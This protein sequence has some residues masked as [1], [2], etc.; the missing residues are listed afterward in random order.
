M[1]IEVPAGRFE[2][3]LLEKKPLAL[4]KLAGIGPKSA[5]KLREKGIL[6]QLDL[7]LFM[8]RKY[9]RVGHFLAGP[10]MAFERMGTVEFYARVMQVRP[11]TPGSKQPLSLTVDCDGQIFK[12]IWFGGMTKSSALRG[13][14]AN[15]WL[16]I[17]G[18]VSYD[19]SFPE[20]SHPTIEVLSQSNPLIPEQY[21][22][23]EP[24]YTSLDGV[25]DAM[26][27]RA[28]L[29]ALKELLP[30][31]GDIIPRP[32][33]EKHDLPGIAQA[34]SVIH[35][36]EP[37]HDLELFF[38]SLRRAKKRLI[39]EEFYTLQLKMARDYASQRKKA[40]A[41][42]LAEREL[43]RTLIKNLPFKLTGDQGRA[44]GTIAKELDS[45]FPMRRL[46][47]GD[48]GSGKTVVSLVSAAMAIDS[49]HQAAL[50]APTD[51][52][53]RQHV[54]RAQE[55]FEGLDVPICFLGGSLNTADKREALRQ[56]E[57]GEARLII[58]THALF[59]DDIVFERLGL[60]MIDEQ[61][62]FGVEQRDLLL[63]KGE[64][65]HLMSMT[66]TPIPRS[67]AHAI[68]GDLDL[69]VIKEKPPG[70]QPIRTVLRDLTRAPKAYEYIRQR[71][72]EHK[73]QAYFVYPMIEANEVVVNRKN[74]TEAAEFL[75]ETYFKELKLA[76]LHGR[77][78]GQEKADTMSDFAAGKIDILCATTVIEVGVDVA[79]A[80][81]MVIESPEVFGLSQL[82]QLR[83]RV[84]RGDAA[85]MCI[86]LADRNAHDEALERLVSFSNTDDGFE[87]AEVDLKMRGPGLFLGKRQAGMAEF[88]FGDLERDK[89][90][91]LQARQ[92][93]RREV[94][95]EGHVA[96]ED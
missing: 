18:N 54:K 28:Q 23:V 82:H 89:E 9:R 58:G 91:L 60:V 20:M 90:L 80:T 26:L 47:Q 59:Q 74:V 69:L 71:I 10:D 77:L 29:Q 53:A 33:V 85:S 56:I 3:V 12:L 78:D 87:L 21:I 73:E 41:P 8:P 40:A 34:L 92:D 48:V 35:L 83:G 16:H 22:S 43:G 30:A 49:G 94:L 66:A 70:R 24:V 81:I 96:P 6:D 50:M 2:L 1:E 46:L 75:Q 13:L 52:L 63:A 7:L 65:P 15:L 57:T 93:A 17:K 84:G 76:I 36:M 95:G 42:R 79:N 27:R 39:Y 32:L 88:R 64:D 72:T 14:E 38:E 44:L 4:D 62:K 61:H 25:K 45:E 5:S 37:Q 55:F 67:L 86:L 11:P 51:I 68:F 31:L 19:R